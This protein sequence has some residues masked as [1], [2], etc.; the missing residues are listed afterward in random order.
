MSG[1]ILVSLAK[2]IEEIE[3]V[4]SKKEQVKLLQELSSPVLKAILGF[5]YDPK[6]IWLIPDGTPPYKPLP[7]NSDQE[8]KLHSE[9]RMLRYFINSEEGRNLTQVKREDMFLRFLEILDPD[10]AAL[11]VRVRNKQLKIA[12]DVIKTAFPNLA[13][14]W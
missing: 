7:K 14:D 13:K 9:Y 11:I 8:G 2:K 4:K 3:K 6:I 1:P 10:D 12:L 5:A